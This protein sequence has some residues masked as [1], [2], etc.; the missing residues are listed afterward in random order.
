L[1]R[2]APGN[3]LAGGPLRQDRSELETGASELAASRSRIPPKAS[4]Q[5]S[6]GLDVLAAPTGTAWICRCGGRCGRS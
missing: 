6:R 3:S 2:S 1:K 4:N 5:R